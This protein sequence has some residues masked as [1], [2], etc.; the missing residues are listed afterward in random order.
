M[1]ISLKNSPTLKNIQEIFS[2]NFDAMKTKLFS[3]ANYTCQCCG[4]EGAKQ[5]ENRKHLTLHID[6]I[7]ESDPKNTPVFVVCK[8]CYL[9]NHIS[10]AVEHDF[11]TLVN[12]SFSQEDLIKI[13]WS[14]SS[15]KNIVNNNRQKAIDDKKIIPLKKDPK[16]YLNQIQEGISS[17]KIKVIFN[18]NFLKT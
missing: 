10:N 14:D 2:D 11:V 18:N 15:K 1:D 9:I 17:G 13:S 6:S 8:S 5:M 3:D 7:D 4:W 12:S 16:I